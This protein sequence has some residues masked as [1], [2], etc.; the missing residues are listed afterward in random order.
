MANNQSMVTIYIPKDEVEHAV[1]GTLLRNAGIKFNSKNAIVQ[2]LFGA[3]QIGGHNLL[4]GPVE[5]QVHSNYEKKARK[6]IQEWLTEKEGLAHAKE[7]E[8]TPG[9][10][11]INR[12][13][14]NRKTWTHPIETGRGNKPYI[15]RARR[16]TEK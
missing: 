1:V 3:G 6:V 14:K 10:R 9:K 11:T 7:K 12:L 16:G 15:P 13:L 4:T 8:I 2:N 5:I